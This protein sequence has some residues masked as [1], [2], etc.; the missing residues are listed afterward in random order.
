MSWSLEVAGDEDDAYNRVH[1]S[2]YLNNDCVSPARGGRRPRT[3]CHAEIVLLPRTPIAA[4]W[5]EIAAD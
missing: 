1:F 3:R 4:D 5:L 2:V